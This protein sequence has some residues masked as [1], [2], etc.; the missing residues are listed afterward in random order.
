MICFGEPRIDITWSGDCPSATVG[1][2]ACP[3]C[4]TI[5]DPTTVP[6]VEETAQCE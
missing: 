3:A 6:V 1:G 5:A 2:G 4:G